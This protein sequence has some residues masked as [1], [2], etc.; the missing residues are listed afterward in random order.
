MS[1]IVCA[2]RASNIRWFHVKRKSKVSRET[3][4]WTG[5]RDAAPP[6]RSLEDEV[7]EVAG[8]DARH[9][10]GLSQRRGPDLIELL[11]SFCRET[12]Q[13]AVGQVGGHSERRQLRE[14]RRGL[15]LAR[16]VTV[17]LD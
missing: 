6:A 14:P 11:S 8:G 4:T 16:Q 12:A 1:C 13:L 5:L 17:V 2:A 3:P 15:A 10:G 9:A 7:V